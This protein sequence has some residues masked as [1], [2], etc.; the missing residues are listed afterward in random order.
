VKTIKKGF[1]I[2][3]NGK[4][5]WQIA[6]YKDLANAL[7]FLLYNPD[8]EDEVFNIAEEAE[9]AKDLNELVGL[10]KKELGTTKKAKH[11]PIFLG[12]LIACISSFAAKLKGKK[13]IISPEYIKRLLKNRNY[14]IEKIKG[15]GWKPKYT[16]E[17]AVKE[18]VESLQGA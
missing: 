5:Q 6:Y 3:G 10:F 2:I 18:T 8:A 13:T 1:P 16:T 17:Q 4:N 11:I 15:L 12:Y 14:S 9:Q 7:V